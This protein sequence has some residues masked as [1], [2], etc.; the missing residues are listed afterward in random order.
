M[1][2][3]RF[4]Y[5]RKP[6]PDWPG[7]TGVDDAVFMSSRDGLHGST[8]ASRRRSSDRASTR[9]TGTSAASTSSA[10]SSTPV[11]G[12]I[13]LYGMEHK[14]LPTM[15]IRRYALRTDGFV[16][17]NAGYCGRRVHHAPA[18][19]RGLGSG[20]QLLHVRRRLSEGRGPGRRG[21]TPARPLPGRQR[22]D[23]RRRDR[24]HGPLEQQPQPRSPIGAN[25]CAS[26]SPSKTPTST[27]SS[28]GSH[29]SHSVSTSSR[30]LVVMQFG[31][32]TVHEEQPRV[33]RPCS[34]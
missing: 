11:P 29:L 33:T 31:D 6:T 24:R 30:E 25:R 14:D 4:V 5:E 10:A 1:F 27:P 16:S 13:S 19:V 9:R 3:S 22:R 8:A 12:E 2:P 20:D 17:V 32:P 26:A 18:P 34:C 23:I 28:S 21:P 7:G 15:R